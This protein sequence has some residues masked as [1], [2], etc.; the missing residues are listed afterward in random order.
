MGPWSPR[1]ALLT[2]AAGLPAIAHAGA[3]AP[4]APPVPSAAPAE[5]AA[6]VQSAA[7][8][9]PVPRSDPMRL[10]LRW[11]APP[12]CPPADDARA[13]VQA[14]TGA[15]IVREGAH[16]AFAEVVIEPSGV[17][18][19]GRVQAGPDAGPN[20]DRELFAEDCGVLSRAIAVV[21]AVGLDAVAVA[22]RSE[23]ASERAPSE[24]VVLP[25][26]ASTHEGGTAASETGSPARETSATR[27]RR[28][29]PPAPRA[30]DAEVRGRSRLPANLEIGGRVALGIGGLVLPSA[31]LGVQAG[32]Y[33]GTRHV[34]VHVVGEYWT[35]RTTE[36][37]ADR[38]AGAELRLATA[39]LRG[40]GVIERGRVRVPLCAGVDAGAVL[41]EGRGTGLSRIESA[42]AP[43]AAVILQPGVALRVI[44]WLSIVAAFE[45]AVSLH[46]PRF[47]LEGMAE[48]DDLFTVGAFGPRGFF[49]L[50]LHA[51]RGRPGASGAVSRRA[52]R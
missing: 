16:E 49:G 41:A 11:T 50:E 38:T 46:R 15:Q 34:H 19:S 8:P 51:P 39:G 42:R 18:F 24:P 1:I 5:T 6:P 7:S 20:A 26:E 22:S 10:H 21:V 14:L 28:R 43:W 2:L 13:L 27:A 47:R 33:V 12:S 45:G 4:T 29:D 52:A 17:G 32:P 25:A 44:P 40:C 36:L 35:A 37:A 31:G 9:P 3:D 48:G 30:A 23:I